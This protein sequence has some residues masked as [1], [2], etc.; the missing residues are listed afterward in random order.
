MSGFSSVDIEKTIVCG[1]DEIRQLNLNLKKNWQMTS[2]HIYKLINK[3]NSISKLEK[4]NLDLT[5]VF[6]YESE[7]VILSLCLLQ[8]E[9]LQLEMIHDF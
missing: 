9:G 7:I 2:T 5:S 4:L 8:K 6:L 1:G 3:I